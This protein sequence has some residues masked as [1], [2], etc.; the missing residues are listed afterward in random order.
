MPKYSF[1]GTFFLFLLGILCACSPVTVFTSSDEQKWSDLDLFA[2]K[3]LTQLAIPSAW[4]AFLQQSIKKIDPH[5]ELRHWHDLWSFMR[6]HHLVVVEDFPCTEE[7]AACVREG[8]KKILIRREFFFK[9]PNI[10]TVFILLHEMTHL[11]E[12]YKHQIIHDKMGRECDSLN[13]LAGYTMEWQILKQIKQELVLDDK[14][15][16]DYA[17]DVWSHICKK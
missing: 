1:L 11:S 6:Q 3:H 5:Y 12:S 13:S 15:I 2:H 4:K 10:A 14:Y 16:T 9:S 8:E 7:T 17:K